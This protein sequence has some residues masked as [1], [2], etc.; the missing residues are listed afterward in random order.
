MRAEKI[1]QEFIEEDRRVWQETWDVEMR[2]ISIG[3]QGHPIYLRLPDKPNYSLTLI[4]P[5][6]RIRSYRTKTVFSVERF[7]KFYFHKLYFSNMQEI[8]NFL[9]KANLMRL[10]DENKLAGAVL[11]CS[12]IRN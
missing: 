9:K 11:M 2:Y 1:I 5:S 3:K 10:V 7:G 8:L 6:T 12:L 4:I